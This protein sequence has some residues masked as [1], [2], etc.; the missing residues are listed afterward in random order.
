MKANNPD[1]LAPLLA[2]GFISTS[3]EGKVTGKAESLADAKTIHWES[4]SYEGGLKVTTF[5]NTAIVTG[6]DTEKSTYKG[7]DSSGKYVWTDVFVNRNGKWQAVSS[8][9]TKVQQ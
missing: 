7:Q 2:A 6:G 9:T 5:G 8:E 4:A 1:M 3:G